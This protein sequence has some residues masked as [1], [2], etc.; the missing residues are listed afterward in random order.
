METVLQVST[1]TIIRII[2]TLRFILSSVATCALSAIAQNQPHTVARHLRSYSPNPQRGNV[3]SLRLAGAAP[4][5]YFE[6]IRR[7]GAGRQSSLS[8][9]ASPPTHKA[10]LRGLAWFASPPSFLLLPSPARMPAALPRA[11]R[12][13]DLFILCLCIVCPAG[14]FRFVQ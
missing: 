10:R 12:R 5:H 8:R 9:P 14:G 2:V 7:Q 3:G 4:E 1:F 11:L 6:F 13:L